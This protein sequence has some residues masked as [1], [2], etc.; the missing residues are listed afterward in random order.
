MAE[1][2]EIF[3]LKIDMDSAIES[4]AELADETARL[5]L[6]N[7][8]YAR[9]SEASTEEQVKAKAAYD[10]SNK[11]LKQNQRALTDLTALRGKEI[12]TVEQGRNAL[13]VLNTEWSKQA[14]LYGTNSKQANKLAGETL[15]LRDRLKELEKGVGDNTR[16]VGNYAEGFKEALGSNN[17]FTRSMQNLTQVMKV[18]APVVAGIK[19]EI[20]AAANQFRNAAA[21]TE[22]MTR[23]QKAAAITSNVLSGALK[24]LKVALISTGIGAIVV[25]LGSLIAFFTN[26]QRGADEVSKAMAGL[27]AAFDVILDRLSSF[28]EALTKLFSGDFSGAFD[29][30][31]ESVSGI[32]DELEREIN[33]AIELEKSLQKIDDAEIALIGTQ[34]ERKKKIEEL[35]FAAKDENTALAERASLLEQ[36]GDLEV[37]IL[38]DQLKIQSERA[39]ISQEQIDLGESTREQLEENQKIQAATTELETQSLKLRRTIEA[40]KQSLLKRAN[41]QAL[42]FQKQEIAAAKKVTDQALKDSKTRL[43]IFVEENK[44]KTESLNEGLVFFED[45]MNQQLALELERHEAGKTNAIEY[46]LALLQIKNEA[47]KNQATLTKEFADAEVEAEKV[48]LETKKESDAEELEIKKEKE[49]IE[50]EAHQETRVA[51]GEWEFDIIR[52]DLE[53][54]KGEELAQA[55]K[56]G[57]D[58]AIIEAKYAAISKRIKQDE[59]NAK[60]QATADVFGSVADL[61]GKETAAGKAA[62]I[63]QVTIQTYL[64]AQQAFTSLSSIPVIGPALGAVAAAVAV[65]AGIKNIQK[66]VNTP[67]PEIPKAESGGLF[68]IGGKRHSSGGTKFYGEDGT[69]FEAEQ[70]ELIGVM[71]RRAASSF[72]KYNDDH[73]PKGTRG[74]YFADGGIVTR[75]LLQGSSLAGTSKDSVGIDYDLLANKIAVANESI[76]NPVVT[77]EDINSGQENLAIVVDGANV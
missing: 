58:T 44:G 8:A 10:A 25:A 6:V 71:N 28:G 42:A 32:G 49:L 36:A 31:K 63:A 67:K 17:L 15:K 24:V 38:E 33:L 73:G 46:E 57:A 13:K 35:R 34:A 39:R 61:L 22:S 48:R 30:M 21:G 52:T 19:T 16:N 60:L 51:Q 43:Q 23:A 11:Q 40:E 76:P 4:T 75:S 50:F 27:G 18:G 3:T 64:G 62:A 59:Q 65:A 54:Q 47:L 14:S 7:D 69:R 5:K 66:I 55:E 20:G 9:S 41:G 26:T 56:V 77:V 70:G 2:I 53:R 72:M 1:T 45:V 68:S 37:A 29:S 12:K 74:N